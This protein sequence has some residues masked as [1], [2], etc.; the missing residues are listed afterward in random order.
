[1]K[2]SFNKH[3]RL[4]VAALA[5]AGMP[6]AFSTAQ[7]AT[8]SFQDLLDGT[9]ASITA[10]DKEFSN[11]T[12]GFSFGTV[13]ISPGDL[14]G[15]MV[16]DLS[17]ASAVFPGTATLGPGPGLRWEDTGNVLN[18]SGADSIGFTFSYDVDVI[19][20]GNM[21]TG[22]TLQTVLTNALADAVFSGGGTISISASDGGAFPT[23]YLDGATIPFAEGPFAMAESGVTVSYT[24]AISA[25]SGAADLNAWEQRFE[26]QSAVVPLPASLPLLAAALGVLGFNRRFRASPAPVTTRAG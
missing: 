26:Q 14:G 4:G 12:F 5:L 3:I 10:E 22:T 1:M 24:V 8:V 17:T 2:F 21:I 16:S 19:T 25:L 18:V 23:V 7:A 9:V 11:F 15:V 6:G 20:A 13:S